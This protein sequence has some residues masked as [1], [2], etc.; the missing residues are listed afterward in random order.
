MI[1]SAEVFDAIRR[2]YNEL[3][4]ANN[5]DIINYFE[6]VEP[7]AMVGH[8]SNIKGILF[9]QEVVSSLNEQ[10]VDAILFEETN[11]VVTDIALMSDGEIVNEMQLKAT[12]S[13]SY[14]NQTLSEYPDVPIIATSEVTNN[15]DST[16]VIDSGIDNAALDS[17]VTETLAPELVSTQGEEVVLDAV[18]DTVNEGLAEAITD[19]ALPIS[20]IGLI[21]ALFGLPFL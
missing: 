19:I 18:S 11:H 2:G 6:D 10:G 14:I 5:I 20:P 7:D 9:E 3:E 15:I 1:Q 4:T 8:L 13:T 12:D 17:I 16:M 21:G